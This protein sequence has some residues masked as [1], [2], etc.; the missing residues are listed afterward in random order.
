MLLVEPPPDVLSNVLK[1][2]FT[3]RDVFSASVVRLR[4]PDRRSA[5]TCSQTCR[6]LD[7]LT[8]SKDLWTTFFRRDVPS[9]RPPS[10]VRYCK[11]LEALTATDC[12]TLTVQPLRLRR[13]LSSSAA[14]GIVSLNIPRSVTWIRMIQGRW[15]VVA[16]SDTLHSVPS[17]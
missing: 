2:F 1:F 16:S 11:A 12:E 7:D 8:R 9:S 15:L 5:L 10:V 6:Y 4:F 17:L 3:V 14:P 13:Q